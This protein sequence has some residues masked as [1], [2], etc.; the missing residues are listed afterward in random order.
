[1]TKAVLV[2]STPLGQITHPKIKPEIRNW[3]RA[4]NEQGIDL[5]IPEIVDY[6]LRRQ[7]ILDN[8]EKSI[9]R[10][11]SLIRDRLILIDR[12]TLLKACDL[13]A[14]VRRQG[15]PTADKQNIDGDVILVAQAILQKK[16]YDEVSIVTENVKHISRFSSYD[17]LIV[18]WSE[19]LNS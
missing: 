19:V 14:W 10:L 7:L 5:L 12:E 16:F 4:I 11:N 2:D 1:M 15:L 13:W 8:R 9:R 17:I 6:E 18:Q 3:L